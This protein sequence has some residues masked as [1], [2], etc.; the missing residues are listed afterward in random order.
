MTREFHT[1]FTRQAHIVGGEEHRD[2]DFCFIQSFDIAT[3]HT[4]QLHPMGNQFYSINFIKN[5]IHF[6]LFFK[7]IITKNSCK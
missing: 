1:N 6:I 4:K 2:N 5:K 3:K 7:Q